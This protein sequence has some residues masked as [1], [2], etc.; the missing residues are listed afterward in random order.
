MSG[1]RRAIAI[2]R[3]PIAQSAIGL[4]AV[5]WASLLLPL[6]TLPVLARELEPEALGLLIFAQSFAGLLRLLPEYGFG[7]SGSRDVAAVRDDP[8]AVAEEVAGV[9]SA[10]LVLGAAAL[11]PALVA[12]VAVP[13]FRDHPDHLAW[14]VLDALA[15]GLNPLWYFRGLEEGVL[16]FS[17]ITFVTR[18]V[19]AVAIVALVRDPQ[20]VAL[21]LA[22][23][24][25]T[26]LLGSVLGVW[27]MYRRTRY[28][29]M[30]LSLAVPRLRGGGHLFV[31]TAAATFYT[32]AN[33]FMLG[34]VASAGQVALFGAAER[35]SRAAVR[36]LAP[37][38]QAIFPRTSY[39]VASGQVERARTLAARSLVVLGA[40]G[41][42][43][44]GVLAL[45]APLI[46]DVV[47]GPGYDGAVD[48]LRILAL[49]VPLIAISDVLG[50]QWMIP[51]GMDRPFT[52]VIVGAG[53]LNLVLLLVLGAAFG[54]E[55]AA[56]AVAGVELAVLAALASVLAHR[57]QLPWGARG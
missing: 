32:A 41:C 20:D 38:S 23:T 37:V 57:R 33:S 17:T 5:Q 19:G 9:M 49:L 45:A 43:I 47:L 40:I 36:A 35:L 11:L 30:R 18:V 13:G 56:F 50:V 15:L 26:D 2:L 6:L 44:G 54:A 34:L 55:G 31:S 28:V 3:H 16:R 21:A 29:G 1:L 24:A 7:L 8:A 14:A 10:K 42:L 25:L 46:V 53:A 4:S 39:L 12:L 48:V 27:M 51:L 22:V 52:A